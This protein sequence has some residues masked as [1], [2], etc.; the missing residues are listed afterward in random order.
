MRQNFTLQTPL[1]E[2]RSLHQF[3]PNT[4]PHI[5]QKSTK[6]MHF[7]QRLQ[8]NEGFQEF[9][10][11]QT[12]P[13]TCFVC[14]EKTQKK[15]WKKEKNGMRTMKTFSVSVTAVSVTTTIQRSF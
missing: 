9:F 11:C 8:H 12:I 7:Y 1:V 4:N 3:T 10:R 13:L 6:I 2:K 5:Q 15:L 14:V